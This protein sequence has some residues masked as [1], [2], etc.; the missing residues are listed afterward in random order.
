MTKERLNMA[1]TNSPMNE[2]YSIFLDK[3]F[4]KEYFNAFHQAVSDWVIKDEIEH[5]IA[6][7]STYDTDVPL[8][9]IPEKDHIKVYRLYVARNYP[10]LDIGT[11]VNE[12]GELSSYVIYDRLAHRITTSDVYARPS[13]SG[14][15]QLAQFCLKFVPK[16]NIGFYQWKSRL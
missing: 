4:D 1:H 15:E 2:G 8:D 6:D 7:L 16:N 3:G 10:A 5:L 13:K 11:H 14:R 9:S 12:E